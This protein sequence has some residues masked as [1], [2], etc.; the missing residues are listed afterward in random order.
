MDDSCACMYRRNYFPKWTFRRQDVFV[1]FAVTQRKLRRRK[2]G[3]EVA[4]PRKSDKSVNSNCLLEE[5]GARV[6]D[7]DCAV[8]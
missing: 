3:T 2:V 1:F 8:P 4:L 5:A 7:R 6:P